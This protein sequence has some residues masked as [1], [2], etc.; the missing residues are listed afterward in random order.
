MKY[1]LGMVILIGGIVGYYWYAAEAGTVS[2]VPLRYDT[3]QLISL[4]PEVRKND[5]LIEQDSTVTN[6]DTIRTDAS[7][8]ALIKTGVQLIASVAQNS[9]LTFT[10]NDSLLE[11]EF[12][13][14][15]GKVWAR[16]ERALEQDE[17]YK[18][19]TPTLV[20]AVRG[21]SFGAYA[22]NGEEKIVVGEG[23][24]SVATRDNP[25]G[26]ITIAGGT[27]AVLED[28]EI[29]IRPTAETEKD[30][31][32]AEHMA[33]DWFYGGSKTLAVT[34][35]YRDGFFFTSPGQ[36]TIEGSGFNQLR[37]IESDAKRIP[38]VLVSDRE[39]K[40][41]WTAVTTIGNDSN[42]EIHYE[43]GV[44]SP[45]AIFVGSYEEL[46]NNLLSF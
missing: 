5:E 44:T 13:L 45:E 31:W 28:G 39:L 12:D 43:Q 46:E 37:Y 18:V 22:E 15:A 25:D 33:D 24:V 2:E 35:A 6:G 17:Q 27:T 30:I 40:L 3:A 1:L 16:V 32:Y 7:G 10:T 4:G 29:L 20:A 21:T 42:V 9:E 36:V 41:P 26:A 34:T 19:Y 23:K 11:T 14:A 8:R 38:F